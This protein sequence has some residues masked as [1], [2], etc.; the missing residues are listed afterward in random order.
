MEDVGRKLYREDVRAWAFSAKIE[1]AKL[2][3][4]EVSSEW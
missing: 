2:R 3:S 4:S 1:G